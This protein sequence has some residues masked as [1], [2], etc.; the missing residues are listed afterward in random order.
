MFQLESDPL[1]TIHFIRQ[2]SDND[3]DNDDNNYKN[4]C[5]AKDIQKLGIWP[6]QT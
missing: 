3:D 2:H 4:A 1:N 6:K 5:A